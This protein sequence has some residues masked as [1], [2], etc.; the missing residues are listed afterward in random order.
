MSGYAPA[1]HA[2]SYQVPGPVLPSGIYMFCFVF[3][4]VFFFFFFCLQEFQAYM[5]THRLK[6]V[7]RPS[8][9]AW[10]RHNVVVPPGRFWA[11]K[12]GQQ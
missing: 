12:T 5:Q 7:F 2:K 3:I 11:N 8:W 9:V 1:N 6:D 4:C 10:I